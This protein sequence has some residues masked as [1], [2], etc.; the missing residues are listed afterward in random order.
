MREAEG[1]LLV[2]TALVKCVCK[3]TKYEKQQ[4][5]SNGRCSPILY[6]VI[7]F[8]TL[9]LL[10]FLTQINVLMLLSALLALI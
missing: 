7:L 9:N 5:L 2:V 3:V 6:I 8:V 10:L 4:H 1:L